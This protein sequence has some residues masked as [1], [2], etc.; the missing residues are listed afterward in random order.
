MART[1]TDP[2][3]LPVGKGS[4]TIKKESPCQAHES[5][6]SLLMEDSTY[7]SLFKTWHELSSWS[8]FRSEG[9]RS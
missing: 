5:E 1:Q 3:D 2:A 4:F 9:W 8:Q 6:K 7:P